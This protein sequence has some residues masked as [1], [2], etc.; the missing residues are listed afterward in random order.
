[1]RLMVTFSDIGNA[2]YACAHMLF[3]DNYSKYH[4]KHKVLLMDDGLG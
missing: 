3:N 2:S 4:M 1:M